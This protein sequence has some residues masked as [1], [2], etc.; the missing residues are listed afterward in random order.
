[1]RERARKMDPE[2][3]LVLD[4]AISY[5]KDVAKA[6]HSGTKMPSPPDVMVHGAAGTGKSNVIEQICHFGQHILSMPGDNLDHPYIIKTAFMGTAAANIN[7]QTLTSAFNLPFGNEYFSLSDKARAL[8]RIQLKNLA[9]VI[10]DEISMVKPDQLYQID[11]RL[12]E[13]KGKR[14]VPYGGVALFCFG[15]IFQLRPVKAGAV[16]T[17]PRSS[18]FKTSRTLNNLWERKAVINL[19]TNHRQGEDR[20]YGDMCNRFRKLVRGEMIKEDIITLMTRLRPLDDPDIKKADIHIVGKVNTCEKIN[21]D[22]LKRMPGDEVIIQSKNFKTNQKDFKPRLENSITIGNTGFMFE[23]KLKRGARV[24]LIKNVDTADL[25]TNGQQG[26]F[27]NF[28][29]IKGSTTIDY[30]LVRFDNPKV[31]KGSREKNPQIKHKFPECTKIAKET[32]TY[33]ITKNQTTATLR[34]F[35]LKVAK[36]I[37]A[38]KS[39][40]QTFRTPMTCSLRLNECW[41]ANQAY[42]MC[43]RAQT[44]NQVFIPDTCGEGLEVDKIYTSQ[45]D[46]D[47]D[48]KMTARSINMNPDPWQSDSKQIRLAHVNIA[49]LNCH[50][51]DLKHDPTLTKADLLHLSETSL[52]PD[53]EEDVDLPD[54]I[55]RHNLSLNSVANGKGLATYHTTDFKLVQ[56]IKEPDYQISVLSNQLVQSIGIYR[57]QSAKLSAVKDAIVSLLDEN[58]VNVVMGDFNICTKKDPDNIVTRCLLDLNFELQDSEATHIKG[59]T[60]DHTY[61]RD[62]K[63][64]FEKPVLHRYSPYYTDHDA[65]CLSLIH[66]SEVRFN[67]FSALPCL[68]IFLFQEA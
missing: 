67:N 63:Q 33:T 4:L 64:I 2:Q 50:K 57:S 37:T 35:P 51:L 18:A 34:Q 15:D 16:Y 6:R 46:I 61:V 62:T 52:K 53:Q 59:G 17:N 49:G 32:H 8:K 26:V 21:S 12:Q 22:Y 45:D 36:A 58:K 11:L 68:D 28:V 55:P 25:L 44:L 54:I 40:G 20:T 42:V 48:T 3:R 30:L 47:E 23:L 56:V 29:T 43:G 14:G 24:M 10:I 9:L 1:M 60:I 19:T 39:Q 65:H 13:I 27:I 38:H 5:F 66:R 41:G 31:G 7:G